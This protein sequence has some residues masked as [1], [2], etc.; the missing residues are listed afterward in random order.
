[1]VNTIKVCL[2]VTD[3]NLKFNIGMGNVHQIKGI[4]KRVTLFR[5]PMNR[6]RERVRESCNKM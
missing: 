4:I 1:M 3:K 6:D 5:N 2:A